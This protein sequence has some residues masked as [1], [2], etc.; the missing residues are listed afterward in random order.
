ML[1]LEA[2]RD[3]KE[4]HMLCENHGSEARKRDKS[5]HE[6]AGAQGPERTEAG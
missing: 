5:S 1:A 6:A 4:K 3:V 2:A